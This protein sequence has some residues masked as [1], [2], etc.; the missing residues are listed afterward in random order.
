MEGGLRGKEGRDQENTVKLGTKRRWKEKEETRGKENICAISVDF[1]DTGGFMEEGC[2][3][4]IS[5]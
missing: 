2:Q 5:L 1:C 3:F 4:V